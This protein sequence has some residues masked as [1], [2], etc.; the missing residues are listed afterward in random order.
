MAEASG[1][2]GK[3]D[4]EQKILQ[5]LGDAPYPVKV[6]HL[7]KKCQVPKKTLNQVLYQ[8]KKE[9]RVA[10]VGPATWQLGKPGT[11]GPLSAELALPSNAESPRQVTAAAPQKPGSQLSV[12]Q[13]KIYKFLEASGP[14]KALIV[15]QFL[16]LKT[17]KEVNPDLYALRDKHL[18][19]H[20]QNSKAWAIYQPE[21]SGEGHQGKT[22]NIIYQQN[23]IN[24]IC[25]NGPNS[26]IS[27]KSSEAVQIG[28]GNS[29]VRQMTMGDNSST[30]PVCLPPLAPAD[31]STQDPLAGPWGPQDIHLE[32][33]VLRRVQLGHGNEMSLQSAPATGPGHGP[34]GSSLSGSPPVSA[35]TADPEALFEI[36]MP[37]PGPQPEA[38]GDVT[39]RVLIKACFLEDATIGNSNRMHVDLGAAGPGGG[40]GPQDSS[41]D[42]GRP[43]G[44]AAAEPAGDAAPPSEAAEP[45]GEFPHEGREAHRDMDSVTAHLEAMTLDSRDPGATEDGPSVA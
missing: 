27:I 23:P 10:L 45:R 40:T 36:R 38:D 1:D 43:A 11:G 29:I 41:W 32:K 18:L 31:P 24:M 8:M 44:E 35:T 15:A 14:T 9:S 20:D 22:T 19:S 2:P 13:E 26:H 21:D 28:H 39:Q 42:G 25:Q 7:V 34:S 6:V 5:V 16:G 37:T 33:S 12:R 3:T 4:L 30:A 17:A